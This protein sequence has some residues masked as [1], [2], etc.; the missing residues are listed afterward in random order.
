MRVFLDAGA[1]KFGKLLDRFATINIRGPRVGYGSMD[2][3]KST[4]KELSNWKAKRPRSE[5]IYVI[6]GVEANQ[7]L[8]K[9]KELGSWA[10]QHAVAGGVIFEIGNEVNHSDYWRDKPEEIGEICWQVW[11]AVEHLGIRVI[12][13]SVSNVGPEELEYAK[14]M[15]SKIPEHIPFAFHRYVEPDLTKPHGAYSSREE[16]LAAIREA[17]GDRELWLTETGQ[18]EIQY[19]QKP[20]PR[21]WKREAFWHSEDE[22]AR[23][24]VEE[25]YYWNEAGIAAIN[26]Y[27]LNDGPFENEPKHHFGWRRWDPNL[28]ANEPPDAPWKVI[29]QVMPPEIAKVDSDV[30]NAQAARICEAKARW[31]R[32]P[33]NPVRNFIPLGNSL[34]YALGAGMPREHYSRVIDNLASVGIG[35]G[36]FSMSTLGWGENGP[37]SQQAPAVIP[38]IKGDNPGFWGYS[39]K[40]NPT[41]LDE[42]EWRLDYAVRRGVRP[43]LTLFWGAFQQMFIDESNGPDT[44]FHEGAMR[45]YLQAICERLKDH[46]QV[47]VELFNEINHG[48]HL[49]MLGRAGRRQFI[50]KWGGFVKDR[51]PDNLLCVSGENVDKNGKEGGY[52]FA[53]HDVDELDYWNVHFDRSKKPAVEGFEPWVRSTWHLNELSHQF[54]QHNPGQG[55]GR[56]DEPMFLQ[57]EAQNQEWPYRWSTLDWEMY[58]VS[59]FVTLCAGVGTTIHNQGGFFLGYSKKANS[60]ALGWY[61]DNFDVAESHKIP[62]SNKVREGAFL[63]ATDPRAARKMDP[64]FPLTEDIYK[65]TRF[66]RDVLDGFNLASCVPYNAEWTG[67][68]VR[69]L[70]DSFKAFSLVGKNGDNILITVLNPKGILKLDLAHKYSVRVYEITGE[71]V[72]NGELPQGSIQMEL[73]RMQKFKKCAILRLDRLRQ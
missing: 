50:R 34:F 37:D 43:Q 68:P 18:S 54:R 26:F 15:L 62:S 40:I 6:H 17:S 20:F 60:S 53:Y 55:Y 45:D 35:E 66:Y 5:E 27:G 13:P 19:R 24:C 47:N 46:P 70:G 32:E 38:F 3:H 52:N 33:E 16:E 9:S 67:S 10:S 31:L 8:D 42:M 48:D 1:N 36:R 61:L 22:I 44:T 59:I 73:P 58:G 12:S 57:T 41:F 7:I 51:L 56:N 49:Y 30:P 14:R 23:Q 63:S 25:L 64:D 71:D 2:D 72:M 69:E 65:V 28:G 29:A 4:V 21:C 39:R 11:M